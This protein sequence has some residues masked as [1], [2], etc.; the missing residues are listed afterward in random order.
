M[1][2][3]IIIWVLSPVFLI[4][5]LIILGIKY[6]HLKD[7]LN[8]NTSADVNEIKT[9]YTEV[10]SEINK[11]FK[12]DTSINEIQSTVQPYTIFQDNSEKFRWNSINVI[13]IIGTVFIILSG[14]IFSTTNWTSMNDF[15]KTIMIFSAGIFFWIISFISERKL[16]LERTGKAFFTLGSIFIPVGI[17]AVGF[18]E[19]FGKRFSFSASNGCTVMATAFAV[20]FLTFMAGALKYKSEIFAM[21]SM[22]GF[23]G[24]VIF[25]TALS[26]DYKSLILTVYAFILMIFGEKIKFPEKFIAYKN[27]MGK[28]ILI[29]T[30]VLSITALLYDDKLNAVSV[31]AFSFMFLRNSF[32]RKIKIFGIFPF[33]I[34]IFF[35]AFEFISPE[36]VSDYALLFCLIVLISVIMSEMNFISE[37]LQKSFRIL[38]YAAMFLTITVSLFD[39]NWEGSSNIISLIAVAVVY[40]NSLWLDARYKSIATSVISP[41]SAVILINYASEFII[42]NSYHNQLICAEILTAAA[43]LVYLVLKKPRTAFSDAIFISAGV[44]NMFNTSYDELNITAGICLFIMLIITASDNSEKILP[45]TASYLT[46]PSAF[47]IPLTISDGFENSFSDICSEIFFI[48]MVFSVAILMFVKTDRINIKRISKGIELW[49]YPYAIINL[50]H[51]EFPYL[52]ILMAMNILKIYFS[53]RNEREKA[54]RFYTYSAILSFV[55]GLYAVSDMNY[56]YFLIVVIFTGFILAFAEHTPVKDS[57]ILDVCERCSLIFLVF[58]FANTLFLRICIPYSADN[59]IISEGIYNVFWITASLCVYIYSS[60]KKSDV[61]CAVSSLIFIIFSYFTAKENLLFTENSMLIFMTALFVILLTAERLIKSDLHFKWLSAVSAV[62]PFIIIIAY[63]DAYFS[64]AM[65]ML[66]GYCLIY[67]EYVK[68][69]TTIYTIKTISALFVA[70]ALHTQQIIEIPDLIICEY[71]VAVAAVFCIFIKRL[72]KGF[73]R[74]TDIISFLTAVVSIIHLASDAFESSEIYDSEILVSLCILFMMVSLLKKQKKWFTLFAVSALTAVF[75]VT[76]DF[77]LSI[78]WWVYLLLIGIM[79]VVSAG[80]NE[81]LKKDGRTLKSCIKNL[82]MK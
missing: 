15:L 19:I 72:W 62:I 29:N 34:Y 82:F 79:L 7:K 24:T 56:Y 54:V 37:I 81:Y 80:I 31:T 51:H 30:I 20:L 27:A 61:L 67:P 23:T 60:V 75:Y 9:Q 76:R 77:W 26:D 64:L 47:I 71:N 42:K 1:V 17:I 65:L 41:F 52:F 58:S 44:I 16:Q 40:A 28:F 59:S 22:S 35:G 57:T 18:L 39:Y 11:D 55:L 14:I 73:E 38:S 21:V 69:D 45:V 49:I 13:L 10:Q 46:V 36:E 4:P 32:N 2:T 53:L 48:A 12:K 33:A 66:A 5:A 43:F 50:H 25:S 63:D 6:Y 68:T 8:Q 70:V 78:D 74:T 3:F